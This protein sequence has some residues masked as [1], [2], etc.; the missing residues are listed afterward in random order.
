MSSYHQVTL[1]TEQLEMTL[2]AG[3]YTYDL[4]GRL[5]KLDKSNWNKLDNSNRN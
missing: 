2:F 1:F 4:L 3:A 5:N